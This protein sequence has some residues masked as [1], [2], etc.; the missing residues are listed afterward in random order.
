[1]LAWK[2]SF[3]AEEVN[4]NCVTPALLIIQ[5]SLASVNVSLYI[6]VDLHACSNTAAYD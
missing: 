2:V 1:M 3:S 5:W 6:S 4:L